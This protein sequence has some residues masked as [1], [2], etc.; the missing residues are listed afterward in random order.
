MAHEKSEDQKFLINKM[1]DVQTDSP[2]KINVD[3]KCLIFPRRQQWYHLFGCETHANRVITTQIW[4]YLVYPC[5]LAVHKDH[6]PH[7][8]TTSQSA[9]E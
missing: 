4:D 5:N 9:L 1:Q 8:K 6:L 3:F 2:E 7:H